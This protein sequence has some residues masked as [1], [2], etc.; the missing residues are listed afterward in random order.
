MVERLA[1]AGFAQDVRFDRLLH[2]TEPVEG[3]LHLRSV[4]GHDGLGVGP[5]EVDEGSE[6]DGG[7]RQKPR[8]PSSPGTILGFPASLDF[9]GLQV[10]LDLMSMLA[11]ERRKRG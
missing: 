1:V 5:I 11:H 6:G 9:A 10:E 3:G 4:L 8:Q 7:E 2:R